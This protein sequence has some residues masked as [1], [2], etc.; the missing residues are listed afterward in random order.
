M[1]RCT[2]HAFTMRA[3]RASFT[4]SARIASCLL[5]PG[6][7]SRRNMREV[8]MRRYTRALHARTVRM[9]RSGCRASGGC[10]WMVST[11]VDST[12]RS[13]R[14]ANNSYGLGDACAR[15][16]HH[17]SCSR[18]AS[19]LAAR[20]A[21]RC[22]LLAAGGG[23]ASVLGAYRKEAQARA[24]ARALRRL[25]YSTR[26]AAAPEAPRPRGGLVAAH[27]ARSGA[28]REVPEL[29]PTPTAP[30]EADLWSAS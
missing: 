6:Q 14:G 10:Y 21:A 29:G 28:L 1:T 9:R 2:L 11:G 16:T 13:I 17:L 19:A 12:L 25:T 7:T 26:A 5:R 15:R 22:L 30:T 27:A 23:R 24:S 20:C 4:T 8:R 18:A 3:M